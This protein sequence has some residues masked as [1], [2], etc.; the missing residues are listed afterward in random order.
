MVI[1]MVILVVF[2]ISVISHPL[3]VIGRLSSIIFVNIVVFY[4]SVISH[5][6]SVI[7]NTEYNLHD[8]DYR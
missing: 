1:L 5:P 6:L 7:A 2:C 3:S 4:I 8:Q